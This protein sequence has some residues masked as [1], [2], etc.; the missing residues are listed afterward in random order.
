MR[1]PSIFLQISCPFV[2]SNL[3][4]STVIARHAKSLHSTSI[5][6]CLLCFN[7]FYKRTLLLLASS[8]SRVPILPRSLVGSCYEHGLLCFTFSRSSCI[9]PADH[10]AL[11]TLSTSAPIF[12]SSSVCHSCLPFDSCFLLF[13]VRE[14]TGNLFVKLRWSHQV[15]GLTR[16]V[17]VLVSGG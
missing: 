5:S 1:S 12:A 3:Y 13:S 11:L 7:L 17:D 4:V 15:R 14:D 10:A 6:S 2:I 9:S 16:T 8:P